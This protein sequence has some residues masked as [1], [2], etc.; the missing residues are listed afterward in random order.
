MPAAEHSRS[1]LQTLHKT[2]GGSATVSARE[3]HSSYESKSGGD[4]LNWSRQMQVHTYQKT[5]RT[6]AQTRGVWV[7]Q[8]GGDGKPTKTVYGETEH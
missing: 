8:H 2:L 3:F 7:A 5:P 4:G 1:R 6:P